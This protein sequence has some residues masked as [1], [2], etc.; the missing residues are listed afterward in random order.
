MTGGGLTIMNC[1]RSAFA[2]RWQARSDRRPAVSIDWTRSR[3]TCTLSWEDSAN[4]ANTYSANQSALV[5]SIIPAN[6]SRTVTG[7]STTSVNAR[8]SKVDSDSRDVSGMDMRP[9]PDAAPI[10]NL[11]VRRRD[12]PRTEYRTPAA[13]HRDDGVPLRDESAAAAAIF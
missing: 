8:Y 11:L 5:L 10:M 3:S 4:A 6:T 13:T 12:R 2:R 7:E 9:L 1:R